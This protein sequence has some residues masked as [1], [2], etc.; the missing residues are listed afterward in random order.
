VSTLQDALGLAEE[1]GIPV[2]PCGP[3]KQPLTEHGFH[4]ASCSIEQVSQWWQRWPDALIGVPTGKA[5]RILVVDVDPD[6]A[7][8]YREHVQDLAAGRTHCTRRGHHLLYQ[9]DGL[10][11]RNSVGVLAPGVDVRGEGGYVIW[12]P[13]EGLRTAGDLEDI[14]PLPAWVLEALHKPAGPNA[15]SKAN[16][17]DSGGGIVQGHRNEYLSGEAFRLRR[18]GATEQQILEVLRLL[19]A[20]R[21]SPP[22]PDEEVRGVAER[23]VRN[24]E[25]EPRQE[26]RR[27]QPIP[28]RELTGEPP[29]REWIIPHWL[30]DHHV[31]LLAGR[32]GI[33]KTLLAQHI[34]TALALGC[35]YLEPLEPRSVLMW[36][37]EDDEAELW[38]RQANICS[39]LGR[40]LAD[41]GGFHLYSYAG[42]DITLAS[43]VY[44]ALQ[45]APML[46]ELRE[47]VA[48]HKPN[49]VILDNVARIYG[50]SEN[51][52][53]GVTTAIAWIQSACAP[54][55]VVLLGHP[56]KAGSIKRSSMRAQ[57]RR[58]WKFR[59]CRSPMARALNT[60][61]Q[62]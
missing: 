6:G 4:D 52:R 61:S 33:G 5:S 1:H 50:G 17:H 12:W 59:L 10:E 32:G 40:P 38:R 39:W 62:L 41:L 53:H 35:E 22:L 47:Q 20:A 29:P 21:C 48:E 58:A 24:V 43:P 23:K 37:G 28:W 27:S 7:E 42:A 55:A 60:R 34:A 14:A 30:P 13:A 44:G 51:D 19:N 9:Y 3:N 31:T 45:P 25:P 11:V 2:F 46:D 15:S 8:W 26:R 16:G 49:V 36:A 54:A 18:Q 57:L 56:A